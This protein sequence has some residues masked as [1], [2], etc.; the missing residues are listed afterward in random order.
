MAQWFRGI[1]PTRVPGRD[2]GAGRAR[3]PAAAPGAA[4]ALA[5][6]AH[7]PLARAS[8]AARRKDGRASTDAARDAQAQRHRLDVGT[9]EI[10]KAIA[11]MACG[12]RTT[13]ARGAARGTD[14]GGLTP[15]RCDPLGFDPFD[16]VRIKTGW[17][18]EPSLAALMTP[19][20]FVEQPRPVS[21]AARSPRSC[22]RMPPPCR[23]G[24]RGARVDG[25]ETDDHDPRRRARGNRRGAGGRSR[26][27]VARSGPRLRRSQDD[28]GPPAAPRSQLAMVERRLRVSPQ[29]RPPRAALRHDGYPT[30]IPSPTLETLT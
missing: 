3:A 1:F 29:A 22:P 10:A 5:V 28:R 4:V 11:G 24:P 23:R 8:F 15:C 17:P 7:P 12:S 18:L 14:T 6:E 21:R 19:V 2:G 25:T 27:P 20:I 16:S 13:T 26:R 30:A 9:D